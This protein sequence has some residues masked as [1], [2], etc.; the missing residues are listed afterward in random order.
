MELIHRGQPRSPRNPLTTGTGATNATQAQVLSRR[1]VN[2]LVRPR[3]QSCLMV[4][5]LQ[6]NQS[7]I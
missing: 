7:P 1:N 2:Y 3:G 4:L 6:C 5:C